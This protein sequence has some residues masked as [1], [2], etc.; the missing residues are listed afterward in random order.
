M[1]WRS[2]SLFFADG[3]SEQH[4]ALVPGLIQHVLAAGKSSLLEIQV[5]QDT[6][7]GSSRSLHPCL[8]F[9]PLSFS[10]SSNLQVSKLIKTTEGGK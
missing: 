10:P 8:S 7:K 4:L 9:G 1:V 6:S 3:M 5:L 2:V